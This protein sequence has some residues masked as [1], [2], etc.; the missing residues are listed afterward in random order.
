[1][2]E[3]LGEALCEWNV[4]GLPSV[5]LLATSMVPS[6]SETSLV[7]RGRSSH[8]IKPLSKVECFFPSRN[9]L[10]TDVFLEC[11]AVMTQT[12]K[13]MD[14]YA[15]GLV[16]GESNLGARYSGGAQSGA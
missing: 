13:T 8:R 7:L 10:A 2:A 12:V 16:T 5:R 1:M 11:V 6:D 9:V 14:S 3:G 4:E 15:Y